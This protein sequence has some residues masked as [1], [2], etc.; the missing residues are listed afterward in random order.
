MYGAFL[1]VIESVETAQG[2]QRKTEKVAVTSLKLDDFIGDYDEHTES[3]SGGRHIDRV[4]IKGGL[5]FK[6]QDK[7]QWPE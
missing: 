2:A 7:S 6:G 3:W 5:T 4:Y 1:A